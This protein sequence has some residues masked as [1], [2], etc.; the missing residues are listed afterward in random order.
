MIQAQPVRR[1]CRTLALA[2]ACVLLALAARAAETPPPVPVEAFYGH[3]DMDDV[4]LAPSGRR[5]ALTSGAG[6]NRVSLAVFDLEDEGKL[7]VVARFHNAD[8]RTFHWVNDEELVFDIIDNSLGG[9]DQRFSR[10]LYSVKRD[11]TELRQLIKARN[12]FIVERRLERPVLDSSHVLLSVPETGGQSVIVGRIVR[13]YDAPSFGFSS[14]NFYAEFLAVRRIAKAPHK[15]F[16]EGVRFQTPLA[17]KP[18]ILKRALYA[19]D[20][21]KQM[22]AD[23]LALADLNPGWS[24]RALKGQNKLPAGITVW[25]PAGNYVP[26]FTAPPETTTLAHTDTSSRGSGKAGKIHR[27]VE[28]DSLWTIARRH[29]TTVAALSTQNGLKAGNPHLRVGQILVLPGARS[30]SAAQS[31]TVAS[32]TT[33]RVSAGDTPFKIANAYRIRLSDLLAANNMHARSVIRPGQHL[34]IPIAD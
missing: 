25:V 18:V 15:Y 7:R 29:G 1:L 32:A 8:V 33:H 13:D 14:R 30:K 10:G 24:E 23:M 26:E 34:T 27:V 19:H 4:A 28:G 21:R 16:P 12:D 11:G 31:K 22:G 9:A 5:L 6:G 3:P 20:I 2:M 17:A